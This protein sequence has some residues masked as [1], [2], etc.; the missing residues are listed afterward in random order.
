[1]R[2]NILFVARRD[3]NTAVTHHV[4]LLHLR[5]KNRSTL[6]PSGRIRKRHLCH[7][8]DSLGIF[9][10]GGGLGSNDS[11]CCHRAQT[12]TRGC[13]A[14]NKLA[15]ASSRRRTGTGVRQQDRIHSAPVAISP[16]PVTRA[17]LRRNNSR[18]QLFQVPTHE[19]HFIG[20]LRLF[21]QNQVTLTGPRWFQRRFKPERLQRRPAFRE[22]RRQGLRVQSSEGSIRS[23]RKSPGTE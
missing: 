17:A 9:A 19:S 7:C 8:R 23:A 12:R 2:E 22:E 5:A 13:C 18:A 16:E 10:G 15:G 21:P 4:P 1:M 6:Q 20:R 3:E 14:L 11:G